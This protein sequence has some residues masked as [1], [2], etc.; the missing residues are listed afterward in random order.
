MPLNGHNLRRVNAERNPVRKMKG[1]IGLDKDENPEAFGGSDDDVEDN[2][3][4]D[5]G[6]KALAI[7]KKKTGAYDAIQALRKTP[8]IDTQ[9]MLKTAAGLPKCMLILIVE[10]KAGELTPCSR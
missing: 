2:G 7:A 9:A 3:E 6:E 4:K 1:A 5:N 10:K 8:N